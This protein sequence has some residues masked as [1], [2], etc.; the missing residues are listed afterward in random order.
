MNPFFN[1]LKDTGTQ[2]MLVLVGTSAAIVAA[3]GTI[4]FGMKS[5]TKKDLAPIEQNTGHLDEVRSGIASVDSRLKKQEDIDAVR[6]RASRISIAASGNQSGNAPYPLHLSV[7]ESKEPNLSITQVELCNENGST[8]GSFPCSSTGNPSVL[9]FQAA[10]PM[11]TIGDWFRAGTPVQTVNRMR[12]KLRVWMSLD[13]FE[14]Y[15]DLTVTVIENT[16][17]GYPGYTLNG[18]V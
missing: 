2:A 6:I 4:Y 3:L 10:I 15:R 17:S 18:S 1:W 9:G 5:L 13:G 8:F 14:V 7:R 11:T 12:L 16:D